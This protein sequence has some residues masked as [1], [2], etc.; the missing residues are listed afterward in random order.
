M[1]Q[2]HTAQQKQYQTFR[3]YIFSLQYQDHGTIGFSFYDIIRN[4]KRWVQ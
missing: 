1:Y 3:K 4:I 2:M